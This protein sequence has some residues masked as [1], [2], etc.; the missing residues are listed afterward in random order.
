MKKSDRLAVER[1]ATK[2]YQAVVDGKVLREFQ[3]IGPRPEAVMLNR[4]GSGPVMR[5]DNLS[6]AECFWVTFGND[7]TVMVKGDQI[8]PCDESS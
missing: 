1:E 7:K 2:R 3:A 8:V 6:E 5:F 4:D